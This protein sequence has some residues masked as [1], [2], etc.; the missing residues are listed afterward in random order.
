[1]AN[2]TVRGTSAVQLQRNDVR[3]RFTL[4]KKLLEIIRRQLHT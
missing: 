3:G 2:K 1:M 4:A